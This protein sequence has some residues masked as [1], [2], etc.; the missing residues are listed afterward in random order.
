MSVITAVQCLSAAWTASGVANDKIDGAEQTIVYSLE[1]TG[2]RARAPT[3]T[4]AHSHMNMNL[5][6]LA[7]LACKLSCN[8]PACSLPAMPS[9]S[10]PSITLR[11]DLSLPPM[12]LRQFAR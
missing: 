2:E 6:L 4:N 7:W 5:H 12:R 3:C 8:L 11:Q 10:R 9:R 1:A